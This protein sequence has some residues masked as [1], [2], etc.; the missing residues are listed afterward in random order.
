MNKYRVQIPH[1]I[2]WVFLVLSKYATCMTHLTLLHS[3][4]LFLTSDEAYKLRS[5]SMCNFSTL[6]PLPPPLRW[7]TKFHIYICIYRKI[8][9]LCTFTFG[10]LDSRW[11]QYHA[12]I[13]TFYC[14]NFATFWRIYYQILC[15]ESALYSGDNIWTF[16]WYFVFIFRPTLLLTSAFLPNK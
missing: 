6:L 16:T 12:Y 13:L 7:K 9:V 14:L 3:A 10:F 1:K 15:Y 2:L 8:I 4:S 5:Y 11:K